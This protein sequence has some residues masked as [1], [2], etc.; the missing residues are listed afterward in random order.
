LKG[1]YRA[2]Q[3]GYKVIFMQELTKK[4]YTRR[5]EKR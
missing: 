2:D 5:R 4:K 1:F 3:M